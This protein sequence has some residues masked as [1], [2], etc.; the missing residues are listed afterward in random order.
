M[1]TRIFFS[2]TI[3]LFFLKTFTYAQNIDNDTLSNRLQGIKYGENSYFQLEGYEIRVCAFAESLDAKGIKTMKS[4]MN[5]PKNINGVKD[6]F[7]TEKN[8]RF[9]QQH[10]AK[11]KLIEY[12]SSYMVEQQP[13]RSLV[14]QFLSLQKKD[15]LLEKDFI[16]QFLAHQI[17][18]NVYV[19]YQIDT[20]N[21]VGRKIPLGRNCE[22][23]GVHNVQCPFYGQMNWSIHRTIEDAALVAHNQYLTTASKW[24]GSV[25]EEK[26]IDVIFEGTAT[27]AK[28]VLYKIQLPSIILGGSNTLIIYYV[29]AKVRG[30]YVS[31][32]LSHYENVN[33]MD[34]GLPALLSE[35]MRLK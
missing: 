25:K 27:K 2:I 5:I 6:S 28:R 20:I 8:L 13:K 26:E 18:N 22:Y 17:P 10:I 23:M 3:F 24:L 15:S 16:H 30:K 21:F 14:F 11:S 31:C 19:S 1:N 35:V 4:E 9:K 29:V 12:S 33:I 7:F 34:T 32:V